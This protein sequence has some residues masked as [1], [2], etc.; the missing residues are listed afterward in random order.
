MCLL[1]FCSVLVVIGGCGSKNLASS[2]VAE[3][4]GDAAAEARQ[5]SQ[6][7]R[8]IN[9]PAGEV[10]S[11]AV[12]LPDLGTRK[13]GSDWPCFLGPTGD[14]KSAETGIITAWKAGSPRIVWQ[15]PLGTSYGAPS[16]SRG[17]L[18]QFDRQQDQATLLCLNSETGEQLWRFAYRSDYHDMFGYNNGPR[19]C[20]VIDEDRVY[21]FGAE[22][23]LHC[24][25]AGDGSILWKIDTAQKYRVVQNFFGVGSTPVIEGDLLIVQIGGSTKESLQL[26]P[27]QLDLVQGEGT[28]VVAFDKRSGEE[29]YRL[30]DEL[31]S[32]ASPTLATINGRRWCFVFA[33][34]GLLGF[35]PASG[36]LDFHYPWRDAGLESVNAS[37]PV[38]VDNRVFISETYGPGSSLLEVWPGGYKLLWSDDKK[39]RSKAMQTHWNTAVHHN[40]YLY[41]SSGR[42]TNNAELR[43]I[44]L[45]SG[46][47]A[48]SEPDLS[49]SS[50]LYVDNHFTCLTEMGEL[51]LL[52]ANPDKFDLVARLVLSDGKPGPH[53]RG[54]GPRSLIEYP[55]WAAP[56]LSHGLLYVRGKDRLVCLELIPQP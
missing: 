38:V 49:R 27:G 33:R 46:K 41:G 14:S 50:L 45:E 8:A 31:A 54:F 10:R 25:S 29:R 30:S 15:K 6:Q 53:L 22:G 34:G 35:E 4:P 9:E 3:A 48:W 12:K 17:R 1:L 13:Q 32:Y 36:K 42:H 44:E 43:C 37:N 56:V 26:P 47:I 11:E 18:F 5:S 51:L 24:L 19:C 23:M 52:R 39:S 2:P 16:I 21:I 7:Q 55:A 40:G 20:P 28:G